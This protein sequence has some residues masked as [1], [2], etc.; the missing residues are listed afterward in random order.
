MIKK[1]VIPAAGSA[2]RLRPLTNTR[3]KS[4]LPIGNTTMMELI[5]NNLISA[6]VEQLL[7]ITGF[8]ADDLEKH[9]RK[10]CGN[11]EPHFIK[12]DK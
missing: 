5:L 3:H 8:M 1:A 4:M 7:I 2:S 11:I 12:N 6:S 10:H 9:V